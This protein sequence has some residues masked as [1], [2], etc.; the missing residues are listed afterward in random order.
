[1]D[2]G[3]MSLKLEFSSSIGESKLSFEQ[4]FWLNKKYIGSFTACLAG[5][6]KLLSVVLVYSTYTL[7]VVS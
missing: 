3:F 1:M 6:Q 7:Q 4:K 5:S 2:S